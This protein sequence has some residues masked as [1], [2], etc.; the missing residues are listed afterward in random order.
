VDIPVMLH[1]NIQ[2][3]QRSAGSRNVTVPDSYTGDTVQCYIAF[4]NTTGDISSSRY[5]G[6]VA[7]A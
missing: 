3:A 5:A 2:Q 7:V 4:I 6:N 1:Q